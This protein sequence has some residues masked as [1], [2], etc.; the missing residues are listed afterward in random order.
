MPATSSSSSSK[1]PD[2]ADIQAH[3]RQVAMKFNLPTDA[4]A[5][6]RIRKEIYLG[7]LPEGVTA[8]QLKDFVNQVMAAGQLVTAADG[9]GPAVEEVRMAPAPARFAFAV[10]RSPE[11][12][13][14]SL[15]LSGVEVGTFRLKLGRPKAY[16]ER[17]GDDSQGGLAAG[18]GVGVAPAGGANPLMAGLAGQGQGAGVAGGPQALGGLVQAG[19][20]A[21]AAA[22]AMAGG[23]QGVPAPGGAGAA[24]AQGGSGIPAGAGAV[25]GAG[26]GAGAG[27]WQKTVATPLGLGGPASDGSSSMYVTLLPDFLGAPDVQDLAASFGAAVGAEGVEGEKATQLL[28]AEAGFAA[29][30]RAKE[31]AAE[32]QAGACARGAIVRMS[33]PGTARLAAESL[34]G[35]EVGPCLL[36]VRQMTKKEAGEEE[37]P[38]S[39]VVFLNVATADEATDQQALAEAADDVRQEAVSFGAVRRVGTAPRQLSVA[40]VLERSKAHGCGAGSEARVAAE[41]AVGNGMPCLPVVCQFEDAQAAERGAARLAG[42]RFDGRLVV[43]IVCRTDVWE[44]LETVEQQPLP[45]DDE[46]PANGGAPQAPSAPAA[47]PAAS[48]ALDDELD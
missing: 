8:E 35:L 25:E 17:Y 13:T 48:A 16:V 26:A 12:A 10:F 6:V 45:D 9:E 14:R 20:G 27:G 28:E 47:A 36:A 4:E 2:V 11:L 37:K 24:G 39:L 30:A 44:R 5:D 19:M 43:A 41:A 23:L 29:D 1:V 46:L 15:S 7:N 38:R 21:N 34:H 18:A 32:G 42:R 22:A 31:A 40:D 3:L 33:D